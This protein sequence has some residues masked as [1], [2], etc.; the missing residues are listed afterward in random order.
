MLITDEQTDKN[1]SF[2][3]I[4]LSYIVIISGERHNNNHIRITTH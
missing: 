3:F 4:F 2:K 1:Y